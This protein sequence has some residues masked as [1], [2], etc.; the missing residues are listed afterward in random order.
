MNKYL[1]IFGLATALSITSVASAQAQKYKIATH[2]EMTVPD[3][4][5]HIVVTPD[6]TRILACTSD[7]RFVLLYIFASAH[8]RANKPMPVREYLSGLVSNFQIS[9]QKVHSS[10]FNAWDVLHG[11]APSI[12]NGMNE[13]TT[14][15]NKTHGTYLDWMFKMY[16]ITRDQA[17]ICK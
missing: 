14:S 13:Y 4:R 6:G 17:S 9:T 5:G 8:H 12:K 7:K 15:F 10:A 16:S 2:E 11:V 3:H 1:Q